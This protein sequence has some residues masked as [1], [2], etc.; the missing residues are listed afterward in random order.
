M[1][2]SSVTKIVFV[3][4]ITLV[5]L[6][7]TK[8]LAFY[9]EDVIE[10]IN[11]TDEYEKWLNLS[12][13]EKQNYIMPRKYAISVYDDANYYSRISTLRS[14]LIS[15]KLMISNY[16]SY[17]LRDDIKITVRNQEGTGQCWAFSINSILESN[18]E[19]ITGKDSPLYSARYTEYATSKTFLD[20]K[21]N[22]SFNREVGDGGFAEIALGLYTSGKGPVLEEDFPFENNSNKINLSD[23]KGLE[24]Q[25]QVKEYVRFPGIYK[26]YNNGN[27]IYKDSLNNNY[28]S[29]EVKQIRDK[30]KKHI[31]NY[32][33]VVSQTYGVGGVTQSASKYY[34]NPS[35]VMKST[36]YFCN[37]SSLIADHQITIIGWDDNYAV[38]NFNEEYRPSTPGA[39]IVLNSWGENFG[40]NGVY[41][42]SY[43]DCFIE[44]DILGIVNTT[45]ISYDNIYQ[46]DELGNNYIISAKNDIY[47]ANVFERKQREQ[48]EWLTQVSVSSLV[49]I[50]CDVYVNPSSGELNPKKLEKVAS[51]VE[52][53][54]GYYT[55]D[56]EKSIKLTGDKFAVIVKYISDE[57]GKSYLGL[58]YPDGYYWNTATAE[59]G[60]SYISIDSE[61]WDDI[62]ELSSSTVIPAKSNL[63]IKAFT[64]YKNDELNYFEINNFTVDD[65]YIYGISPKT[66]L[67]ELTNNIYT[68]MEYYVYNSNNEIAKQDDFVA[69]GMKIQNSEKTYKVVVLGDLNGDG[70]ITITDV[71]KERLHVSNISSLKDEFL[72][73]ADVNNDK[74]VTITDL[75]IINLASLNIRKI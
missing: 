6:I 33:G 26:T 59:K 13:E 66:K 47:G 15:S 12:D 7:G 70:K 25:K 71:V 67:N 54:N 4:F 60:Q 31:I 28:T 58:E 41:Y 30:I 50:T 3:I 72:K 39:Y 75:V 53:K 11:Y 32:G 46:Y 35:K 14:S 8:T 38:T 1:K 61:N 73:A 52:I 22:D 36:A 69:T 20:G 42:I 5:L 24:S 21:N 29:N 18:I 65:E 10:N 62:M 44:K 64:E 56:L 68:N 2:K 51:N 63:C 27:V 19:K 45:D 37:N 49:D 74:K 43:E 17:D 48:K 57:S 55:L 40:D 23:I 34:N 9:T 16:D